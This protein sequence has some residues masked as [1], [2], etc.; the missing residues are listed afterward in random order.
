MVMRTAKRNSEDPT[1]GIRNAI[2]EGEILPNERLIEEDLCKRFDANRGSVRLALARLEQEG[3]VTRE[4]NRGARVRF[5]PPEEAI[6]IMQARVMLEALAARYAAQRITA[7]ELA[8][9]REILVETQRL[10]AAGDLFGCSTANMR[11]HASIVEYAR[12][13]ITAKLLDSLR[14]QSVVYQFQMILEPGRV[15]VLLHTHSEVV[16]AI[17][18]RDPDIAERVMRKHLENVVDALKARVASFTA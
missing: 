9:L 14:A 6:Q 18:S 16:E 7:E 12:H 13:P 5:V 17:A 4:P 1:A 11:L 2:V 3:L 8:V 15:D 10:A